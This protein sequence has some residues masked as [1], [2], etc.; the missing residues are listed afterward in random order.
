MKTGSTS[1]FTGIV[2]LLTGMGVSG[3]D[4]QSVSGSVT[5]FHSYPLNNVM[6]IS[7]KS[8]ET[9]VTG[10][11]GNFSVKS[12]RGDVLIINASGFRS[13]KIKVKNERQYKIDLAYANNEKNFELATKDG[14][15]SP[16]LLRDGL[17][18]K[19]SQIKHDFSGYGS[20]YDLVGSEVYNVRVRGNT[21][22]S[23]KLRSLDQADPVL[24][25]VDN[26]IVSDISFVDPS[27]VKSIELIDDVRS[28]M[29]GSMG[30]N[31]ILRITL[32]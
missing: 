15:I 31:G 1:L 6:V 14:H 12:S 24:L 22:L 30:A 27:W 21:I 5:A 25:V 20:I 18:G 4:L 19:T 3:Q 9:A 11:D 28:T 8:G 26:R 13:K 7:R 16:Q 17:A 2:L 32:K 10:P 23:T 29:Y